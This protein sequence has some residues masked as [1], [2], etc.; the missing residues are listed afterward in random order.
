[1]QYA[2]NCHRMVSLDDFHIDMII[3]WRFY[4]LVRG[5]KQSKLN[6]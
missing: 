5:R 4:N 6:E 3:L 2:G 1:M